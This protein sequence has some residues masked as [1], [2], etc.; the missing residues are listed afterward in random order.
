LFNTRDTTAASRKYTYIFIACIK[1]HESIRLQYS[2]MTA[3]FTKQT[4]LDI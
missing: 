1:S 4:G 3:R 2:Q